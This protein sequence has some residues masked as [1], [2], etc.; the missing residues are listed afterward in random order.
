MVAVLPST[1]DTVAMVLDRLF[2]IADALGEGGAHRTLPAGFNHLRGVQKRVCVTRINERRNSPETTVFH[3]QKQARIRFQD[4]LGAKP[5]GGETPVKRLLET[6]RD[7]R[8]DGKNEEN[9]SHVDCLAHR[10]DQNLN[11]R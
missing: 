11:R 4:G 2:E 1:P 9:V 3:L 8:S 6:K 7:S 5:F 10:T